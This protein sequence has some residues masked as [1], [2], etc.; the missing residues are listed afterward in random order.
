MSSLEFSGKIF[1]YCCPQGPAED[2]AYQ[3]SIV[4]LAEGLKALGIPFFSDRNYWRIKP[5]IEE[6]LFQND[7]SVTPDDCS[8]VIID[9]N[10]FSHNRPLPENLFHPNHKYITVYFEL[11]ASAKESRYPSFRQFD[12]IFRPH[13]NRWCNYPKNIYPWAF[14]LSNRILRETKDIPSFQDR[15]NK[16]LVNFRIHNHPLRNSISQNFL[17]LIDPLLPVDNAVDSF[18]TS[19]ADPYHHLQWVQSG[20][21]HYPQ[22]YQ[23]LKE[24]V[25]CACFGGLFRKRWPRDPIAYDLESPILLYRTLNFILNTLDPRPMLLMN[26]ESFRFWESMSAGCVS[27][28]VNLEKYGAILPTM[29]E[30]WKHYIGIDLENLGEAVDLISQNP[31]LLENISNQGR[32]W[33]IENY[34]PEPTAV[35]FLKIVG[36]HPKLL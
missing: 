6:Y 8:I 15:K 12:Y 11:A 13:Y 24:S 19:P 10:W 27:F 36:K 31:H 3:H 32:T 30:N 7:P 18:E 29:P 21:R 20:K 4:C 23:R 9:N 17:P 22:Y 16:L 35:R 33:A 34:S 26:W 14:G 2:A 28:H 5:E 1:F 25:G